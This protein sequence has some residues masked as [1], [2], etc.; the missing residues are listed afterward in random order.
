MSY[1]NQLDD[2]LNSTVRRSFGDRMQELLDKSDVKSVFK[3]VIEHNVGGLN[4]IVWGDKVLT[5]LDDLSFLT[6]VGREQSEDPVLVLSLERGLASISGLVFNV[7]TMQFKRV[8]KHARTQLEAEAPANEVFADELEKLEQFIHHIQELGIGMQAGLK[9]VFIP[10]K[11]DAGLVPT[12]APQSFTVKRIQATI[13]MREKI[14]FKQAFTP[15]DLQT[16]VD[17]YVNRPN[18]LPLIHEESGKDVVFISF[19]L[20]G[21][22]F[23]RVVYKWIDAP[24]K[25]VQGYYDSAEASF[26]GHSEVPEK[27]RSTLSI[28]LNTIEQVN[29]NAVKRLT[30]VEA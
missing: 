15:N 7:R 30:G 22:H 25:Y 12:E 16:F 19:N 11:S 13:S 8:T 4:E 26:L 18:S 14:I 27:A 21:N 28:L 1:P 17:E 5:N 2:S 24:G 3:Y 9:N 6:T 29:Y 23:E 20:V 10:P